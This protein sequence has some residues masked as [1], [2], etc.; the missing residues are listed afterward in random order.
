MFSA[1]NLNCHGKIPRISRI[2]FLIFR[3]KFPGDSFN[4]EEN[5]PDS[6]RN[7][8]IYGGN[9]IFW[10]KVF[11]FRK[12]PI[13]KEKA[14]YS[15]GHDPSLTERST[16]L[17]GRVPSFMRKNTHKSGDKVLTPRG[18]IS[19][20]KEKITAFT[21]KKFSEFRGKILSCMGDK[22]P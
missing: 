14:P 12:S 18:I 6:D 9:V 1:L 2:N 3:R 17:R 11:H 8:L 5:F 4:L 21:R 19:H 20:F 10:G 13:S 15:Q 22:K 16:I 7:F